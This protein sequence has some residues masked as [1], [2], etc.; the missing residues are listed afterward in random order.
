MYTNILD[1][2]KMN[3]VHKKQKTSGNMIHLQTL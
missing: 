1:D 3:T 2:Y